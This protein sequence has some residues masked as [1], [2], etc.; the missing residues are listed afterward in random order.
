MNKTSRIKTPAPRAVGCSAVLEQETEESIQEP[1][2]PVAWLVFHLVAA[3]SCLSFARL[4]H[5]WQ[6]KRV[7]AWHPGGPVRIGGNPFARYRT[8]TFCP[9]CFERISK[10]IVVQ[11]KRGWP[12]LD[13]PPS[14]ILD[15]Q[16]ISHGEDHRGSGVNS[17]AVR[18]FLQAPSADLPGGRSVGKVLIAL[19]ILSLVGCQWSVGQTVNPDKPCRLFVLSSKVVTNAIPSGMITMGP[20]CKTNLITITNEFHEVYHVSDI[21]TEFKPIVWTNVDR[22]SVL[23]FYEGTNAVVISTNILH[24]E[25]TIN[26]RAN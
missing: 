4:K 8:D 22:I 19:A 9:E 20:P 10:T 21:E 12:L 24:L 14:S 6:F 17:A 16:S 7:C 18:P 3:W 13:N 25:S 2:N 5:W 15:S 1:F 26:A 11:G 23:G